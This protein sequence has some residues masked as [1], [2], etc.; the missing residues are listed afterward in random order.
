MSLVKRIVIYLLFVAV[1]IQAYSDF[2]GKD[3]F[4]RFHAEKSSET[5]M[6]E[7][8]EI[9]STYQES[10]PSFRCDGRQYCSEMNSRAEAVFFIRNCPD[11]KMDG[12]HDGVPCESDSRF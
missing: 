11:T 7:N 10:K 8:V 3:P 6:P 9:P 2:T 12:D 5:S 1:G 4:S